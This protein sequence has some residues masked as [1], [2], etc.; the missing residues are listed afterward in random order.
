VAAIT[1][2]NASPPEREAF[3][4]EGP[5]RTRIDCVDD[6]LRHRAAR[7]SPV[8]DTGRTRAAV[9]ESHFGSTDA[10]CRTDG[11]AVRHHTVRRSRATSDPRLAATVG[12]TG[13]NAAAR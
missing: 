1:A 10:D 11:A 3:D 9:A 5:T 6:W 13:R 2:P 4:C 8:A 12:E 7:N